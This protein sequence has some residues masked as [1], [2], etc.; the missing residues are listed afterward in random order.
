MTTDKFDG[1]YLEHRKIGLEKFLHR[2][3]SHPVLHEDKV[4]KEFL[5]KA[6]EEW[7]EVC[8]LLMFVGFSN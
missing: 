3:A 8:L 6:G 5:Q 1:E 2:I 4:F 7:K